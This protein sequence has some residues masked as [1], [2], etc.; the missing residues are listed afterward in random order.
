VKRRV[1]RA[2]TACAGILGL[3][4]AVTL[5]V[6]SS[7]SAYQP[8]Q[9][10]V[11][12]A[13]DASSCN[14]SPCILYPKSAQLPSGRLVMTFEDSEGPVVG[15]TMPIYKSDD[16]GDTWQKLTDLQ[17]PAYL[18]NDSA[19][20]AYTS[21]WTNPYFYVLPQALG[22]LAA[23]TLL[24]SNVVSGEDTAASGSGNRQNLAI[25]L[26]A[27]TDQG[28]TWNVI[29]TVATGANQTSDPVW[30]PYLMMY[31]GK[32]VCYY[33]D[34]NDYLGYNSST[35]VPTIDP[36]NA[37][38][39]DSGG[40]VLVHKTWSG[41]GSWSDPVLDVAGTTVSMGSGKTEIGGGRPGMTNIVPT[42]DGKWLLTY[43]YWG[44]GENTRYKIADNPLAFYASGG[45]IGAGI[46]GL[47][48]ASGSGSLARGGSPVV[49][50]R[51]DGSLVYNAAG[52][53][54]LWVNATGSSTGTWAQ[55]KTSM[56]SGYSRNLQHV[57]GTG[58]MTILR[59][60][61]GTG[62]VTAGQVD[63]G[64][65][66]G[67]YYALVNRATGQ[68]LSPQTGK[69]QD[70]AFTGDVPDIITQA[71]NDSNTGQWWHLARKGMSVTLLNKGGGRAIGIWQGN[72]SSGTKLTQW[73][74][75]GASDKLWNLVS[76]SDGYYQLQSTANTS[77][78]ATAATAGGA[79]DLQAAIDANTNASGA[80]TQ[81]WQLVIDFTT[82]AG[83]GFKM[84]NRNS[85]KVAGVNGGST[86]NGASIVQWTDNGSADQ[87]WRISRN[88]NGNAVL[89]NDAS[90]KVVGVY[91]GST[92]QGARAV[93]WTSTGATN[94]QWTFAASGPYYTIQNVNSNLYL[95]VLG[96]SVSNGAEVVQWT[97]NG[98][99]DQQWQLVQVSGM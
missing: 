93:Q 28:A 33:S 64:S 85:G 55:Y 25:V 86:A 44:S 2:V 92:S 43:E 99:L 34:E 58:R 56:P 68:V 97:G 57:T 27:S 40:Q 94:Q 83:A 75:D 19:Y 63:L 17:A 13:E 67:V 9:Q 22:G 8:T 98:S 7:A 69:A 6:T 50:A 60:P 71:R 20:A 87:R 79:V 66:E 4:T 5:A 45:A 59:A 73:V 49:I 76:T 51:P 72:A 96:G 70:A 80:Q 91:Q 14:K 48:V 3:V 30:E 23:G 61:W 95:G 18:T 11:Y 12:A 54:D 21:N 90:G 52:S 65:S 26:Y 74:D 53:G 36:D 47:P 88:A 1:R 37:T 16:D 39:T 46:T 62:P 24:L 10:T 15:Q 81:Q 77:L 82:T 32:L 89:T 29:S 84:V 31:D 42:S 35:G 78:F 41:S 38:A